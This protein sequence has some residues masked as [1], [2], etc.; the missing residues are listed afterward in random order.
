MANDADTP[1]LPVARALQEA[2]PL[3]RLAPTRQ[4]DGRPVADFM[5]LVPGLGQRAPIERD[6]V[7]G[8]IREACS[9]Y[10]EQVV[11]ADVNYR[12]NVLW[13]STVASPGLAGRVA[14]EI[15][16]RVPEALLVGGQLRPTS[17]PTTAAGPRAVFQSWLRG[18]RRRLDQRRRL[19]QW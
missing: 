11:F 4:A 19:R 3:W 17:L 18:M 14:E 1:A 10:G 9:C 12:I 8:L 7:S 15:R 5:M 16:R 6:R 13:V 2:E